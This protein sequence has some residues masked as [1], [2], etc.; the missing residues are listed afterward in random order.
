MTIQ[1]F[2][3]ERYL[4]GELS[5]DETKSLEHR[6]K[7]DSSAAGALEDLRREQRQFE[8]DVPYAAF[9]VEHERRR[10]RGRGERLWAGGFLGIG[11]ALVTALL[12]VIVI[13]PSVDEFAEADR[14]GRSKGAAVGLSF[15]VVRD[16]GRP[17]TGVVGQTVEAGD[18]VQ[19]FYEA[20]G[21]DFAAVFGV[22]GSGD[23]SL[24]WPPSGFEM[25]ELAAHQGPFE[26][27]LTLDSVP[28]RERFFAVFSDHAV[29]LDMLQGV[30]ESAGNEEPAWPSAVAVASTWVEKPFE[31]GNDNPQ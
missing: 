18:T 11:M 23:V 10:G 25:K 15:L 2:T 17:E 8:S 27:A 21:Y 20:S 29:R 14:G 19:L 3:L 22:D 26:F 12:V 24:Y 9:R 28:G 4:A 5:P 16:G 6:L 30:L 13:P 1:R 31:N 7:Q